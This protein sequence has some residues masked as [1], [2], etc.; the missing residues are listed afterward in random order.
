MRCKCLEPTDGH[1]DTPYSGS[2]C[3]NCNL[4]EGDCDKDSQCAGNLVC[5]SDNCGCTAGR[6]GWRDSADCCKGK[7]KQGLLEP[8]GLIERVTTHPV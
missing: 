1:C 3:T 4:G 2:Y 8:K 6:N 5:G 7:K